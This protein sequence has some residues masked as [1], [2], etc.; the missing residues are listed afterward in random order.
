MAFSLRRPQMFAYSTL[1]GKCVKGIENSSVPS[2]QQVAAWV[3][4]QHIAEE[5]VIA[6]GYD[7]IERVSLKDTKTQSMLKAYD[8]QLEL[9]KLKYWDNASCKFCCWCCERC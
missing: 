3:Q 9:W 1:V 5:A 8:R 7:D 2:D 6:L 4:L